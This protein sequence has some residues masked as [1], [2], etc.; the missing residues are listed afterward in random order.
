M[1]KT[2]TKTVAPV[3]V[4]PELPAQNRYYRMSKWILELGEDVDPELLAHKAT[5]SVSA[6]RYGKEAHGAIL[7]CLRDAGLMKPEPKAP[8]KAEKAK[9]PA[10][11]K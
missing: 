8:V 10:P 2:T 7:Q 5:V 3:P 1:P 6:A 11:A 4:E 9:E